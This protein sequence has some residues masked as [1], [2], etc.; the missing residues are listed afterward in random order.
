MRG[1]S[2]AT[3]YAERK[4]NNSHASD[5]H[6]FDQFLKKLETTKQRSCCPAT[7]QSNVA[8]S[9][10]NST[11]DSRYESAF[12]DYS[13]VAPAGAY[14][15][16]GRYADDDGEED[17]T[18]LDEVED[19]L[20]Q[21]SN[22]SRSRQFETRQSFV[23]RRSDADAVNLADEG[24]VESFIKFST[25]NASSGQSPVPDRDDDDDFGGGGFSSF[26]LVD[27]RNSDAFR[28]QGLPDAILKVR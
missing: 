11:F 26:Q 27:H 20:S 17:S 12:N 19:A 15:R 25:S 2:R 10:D 23:D 3:E 16:G 4:S 8:D 28:D 6:N 24:A 13:P 21:C 5:A 18:H 9:S 14:G 7:P 22:G 1:S